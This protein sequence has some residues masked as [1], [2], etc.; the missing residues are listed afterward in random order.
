MPRI[1]PQKRSMRA[2]LLLVM[3]LGLTA[4]SFVSA[5]APADARWVRRCH[6]ERHHHHWVQV[7]HRVW[8]G[9]RH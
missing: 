7:C 9:H 4:G 3:T 2:T 6:R 5:V 1:T 8:R